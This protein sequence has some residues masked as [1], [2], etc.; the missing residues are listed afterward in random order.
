[1]LIFHRYHWGIYSSPKS[2]QSVGWKAKY[3]EDEDEDEEEGWERRKMI[4][5]FVRIR[6]W[7][8]YLDLLP[9]KRWV[10]D[11]YERHAWKNVEIRNW[12]KVIAKSKV[13]SV[14]PISVLGDDNE[15]DAWKSMEIWNGWNVVAKSEVWSGVPIV[16]F[17]DDYYKDTC[18]KAWR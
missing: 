13:W 5:A 2:F 14:V 10:G 18:G 4:I 16:V 12:W 3:V 11:D 17:G 8:R 15:K 1:M 6:R 9:K 7:F